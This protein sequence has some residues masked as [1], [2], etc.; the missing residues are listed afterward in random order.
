MGEGLE[1]AKAHWWADQ[2]LGMLLG[3]PCPKVSSYKAHCRVLGLVY[4]CW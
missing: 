2:A 1:L 3:G 4:P